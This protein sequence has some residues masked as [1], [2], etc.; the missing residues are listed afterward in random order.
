MA[1]FI[2]S[3]GGV[4]IVT[5]F[6]TSACNTFV[7]LIRHQIKSLKQGNLCLQF[8]PEDHTTRYTEGIL[9]KIEQK[10]AISDRPAG[11]NYF[12]N[13]EAGRDM[14]VTGV[15]I[16]EMPDPTR[17]QRRNLGRVDKILQAVK[18]Q[19]KI[20]RI[21]FIL[22]SYHNM[23]EETI[24]WFWNQLWD[25]GLEG[26]VDSGL[27]VLCAY[28][29]TDGG[30][31]S[32]ISLPRLDCEI[33]LPAQYDQCDRQQVLQQVTEYIIQHAGVDSVRAQV[34]AQSWLDDWNYCPSKVQSGALAFPAQWD[35]K[36]GIHV[37]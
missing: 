33:R 3:Q 12:N 19:V 4:V 27:L 18:E 31:P 36:L 35:P 25:E 21:V 1:P 22:A 11:G 29:A 37:T 10:L 14:E 17:N 9:A 2:S 13:N 34:Y 6:P 30:F 28:E 24:S 8:N 32:G 20:N 23:P 7:T 15:F 5:G 26:L 16:N